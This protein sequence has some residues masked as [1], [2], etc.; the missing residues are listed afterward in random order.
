MAEPETIALYLEEHFFLEKDLKDKK[1]MV[2]AG[3]TYESIDPVRFI[4]NHSSGKMGLALCKE[5]VR[6]GAEVHLIL[7]PS[8]LYVSDEGIKVQ[9]VQSAEQMYKACVDTFVNVDIAVMAAAVADFTPVTISAEKIKKTDDTL[10]IELKQTKD[11]L[12]TLGGL[13]KN[14]QILIGFALETNNETENA[15]VKL[16]KKNADMIVLNSLNDEGAGFSFDTNKIT[17]I[18]KDGTETPF[19][20]KSKQQV[21][22]DIVDTI[23]KK[24]Y[25]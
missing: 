5:F 8:S 7:G 25:V 15:R 12:K 4:G 9:K 2:A 10:I 6:R 22:K 3:P 19:E 18:H 13:K 21:A 17:I 11:I 24:V 20:K 14:G 23:I 1:V 16:Q